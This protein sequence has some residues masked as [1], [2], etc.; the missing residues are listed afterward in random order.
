VSLILRGKLSDLKVS[1][2]YLLMEKK[3]A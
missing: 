1:I 2:I 3:L